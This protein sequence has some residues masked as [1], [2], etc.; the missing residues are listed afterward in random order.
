MYK[1]DVKR[2]EREAELEAERSKGS[3]D[4]NNL[5]VDDEASNSQQDDEIDARSM[6][7]KVS[8]G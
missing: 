3:K 7:S 2:K 1:D 4:L 6:G 5:I 8:K